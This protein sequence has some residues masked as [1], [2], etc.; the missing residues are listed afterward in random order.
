[1]IKAPFNFVPLND[2]PYIVEWA[3]QISQDI[4]FEDAISG[5]LKL[6]LSS[7]SPIFINNGDLASNTEVCEFC[8]FLNNNGKKQYFIP[9]SSIKGMI[10]NVMEILSFGKMTQVQ[11]QSFG[12]RDLSTGVDGIFY[13]AKVKVNNVHCGW[14]RQNGNSYLLNDCGLPWRISAEELDR[15]F[16]MGLMDFITNGHNFKSDTNKTAQ[17]KYEMFYSHRDESSLTDYFITDTNININAG[18]RKFVC[19]DYGGQEGTIVFTGQPGVRQQ[20]Y[21]ER[22]KKMVWS[23]KFFEF[24]FP[25]QV[26]KHDIEIPKSIFKTFESIHQNSSDYVDFRKKQLRKGEEIPVFFI[27]DEDGNIDT[28]GISYMYKFPAFNSVYNGIPISLLDKNVHDLCEC[29]LGY[30]DKEESLKGRV[31]FTAAKLIGDPNF[32]RDITLA[33]AKPHPSYYPLYLGSGQTWNTERVK[34]A[35]RKRYI[36]RDGEDILHNEGTDKMS[37]IIRPLNT[38]AIFEGTIHFHNLRPIELGALLSAIDF[39]QHSDCFHNIGQGKPLGYGKVRISIIEHNFRY[40]SIEKSCSM[41]QAR[42]AFV[43]EME[44]KFKGWSSSAL[45]TELF[46]I[47]RGIPIDRSS[48]FRYMVMSIN[49]EENEFKQGLEAY[50]QGEQLG[51]FCQILENKAPRMMQ[52]SNVSTSAKR[53]DVEHELALLHEKR[54]KEK[55]RLDDAINK[56]EEQDYLLA[57]SLFEELDK[58]S[59]T[60]H[61][62]ISYYLEQIEQLK[63][64]ADNIADEAEKAYIN[65]QYSEAQE[66]YKEADSY[67]FIS[68]QAQ[69]AEC[70]RAIDS[71]KVLTLDISSYLATVK[72]ASIAAFANNLKKRNNTIP[73]SD[74]DIPYIIQKIRDDWKSLKSENRKSWLD[75]KKWGPIEKELCPEFTNAIYDGVKDLP[76]K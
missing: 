29:I 17:R 68:Y 52:Q 40:I 53:I 30:T 34:L 49:S 45:L 12:I 72:L 57:K 15:H 37:R 1:M 16:R 62:K 23:G 6:R 76:N 73:L 51:T 63:N 36:I 67:H 74:K 69:I 48:Q 7:S 70:Q 4:P 20:K 60:F 5:T 42:A 19:F 47:A 33:L 64:H 71:G 8:N 32:Y 58:T 27:Y 3:N 66:L 26:I 25:S 54:Q 28:M 59:P 46:A 38:G 39:C 43:N 9:G 11:N 35:G 22:K 55:E 21:N 13:R 24:V 44:N 41:E 18:G 31:Q 65:K 10:R 2:K 14:L 50:A 61:E 75:K 56:F